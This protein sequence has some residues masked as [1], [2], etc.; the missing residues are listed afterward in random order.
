MSSGTSATPSPVRVL[1][2]A[3][4]ERSGSTILQNVLGLLPGFTPVGEVGFLWGRLAENRTR[5]GCGERVRDCSFWKRVLA[6]V[7]PNFA[8]IP[9]NDFKAEEKD[10]R[11]DLIPLLLGREDALRKQKLVYLK[12]LERLYLAIRNET[13]SRVVIDASKSPLYSCS[14]RLSLIHI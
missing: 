1:Y 5:C 2:V 4:F 8:E 9:L 10:R 6:R 3:G 11:R 13:G 7:Y 12:C 14:L